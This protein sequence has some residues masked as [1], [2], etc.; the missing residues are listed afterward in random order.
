MNETNLV[1]II[2]PSFNSE[3]YIVQSIESVLK[4]TYSNWELLITDDVSLDN[5][6]NIIDSYA[7]RDSRIKLFKLKTN[8]GPAIARNNSLKQ[9]SGSLISFL[10]SDDTWEPLKLEIQVKFLSE[11][12]T[13]PLSFTSYNIV[14]KSNVV[15]RK[16]KAPKITTYSELLKSCTIGCSTVMINKHVT[17]NILMPEI[18]KRQ[19]FALWLSI[20]KK[21]KFALGIDII[22][23]NYRTGNDSVSSNK[24]KVIKY[25]WLTY[26][27]IENLGILKSLYYMFHWAVRGFLKHYL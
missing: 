10:D 20:L 9:S 15:I 23:T 16:L 18:K 22:L 25:Q 26:Y 13:C 11:N 3:H 27:K 4:Q 24:F 6:V 8:S 14:D 7:S 17:G 12:P 1:S 2:M 19:D 5:T 21:H